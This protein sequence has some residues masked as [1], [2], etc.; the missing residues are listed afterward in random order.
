[1]KATHTAVRNLTHKVQKD[2]KFLW[3]IFFSLAHNFWWPKRPEKQMHAWQCNTNKRTLSR[4]WLKKL[5]LKTGDIQGLTAVVWEDIRSIKCSPS[6]TNHQQK[7]IS[8]IKIKGLEA[9]HSRTLQKRTSYVNQ[10][11]RMANSYLKTSRTLQWPHSVCST[12][13]TLLY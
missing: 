5:K 2:T 3:T 7:E 1:M 6:Q 10:N 9:T 13:W 8:V 12:C 4:L 11:D